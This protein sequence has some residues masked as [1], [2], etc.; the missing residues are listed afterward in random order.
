MLW[1]GQSYFYF[2]MITMSMAW[3]IVWKARKAAE[4]LHWNLL[5]WY[6]DEMLKALIVQVQIH[7]FSK[8]SSCHQ[9][10][11]NLREAC[12]EGA[13]KEPDD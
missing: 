7:S 13:E 5:K 12:L 10:R 8:Y 3:K 4:R 11:C 6:P 9:W 2:H 1:K